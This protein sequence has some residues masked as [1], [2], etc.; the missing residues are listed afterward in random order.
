GA[1]HPAAAAAVRAVGR[2]LW[3]N[4]L[5]PWYNALLTA[6][7]LWLLYAAVRTLGHWALAEAN[8]AVIP[9]NL[10]LFLVGTYPRDQLWRIGLIT[11]GSLLLSGLSAGAFGGKSLRFAAA[12]GSTGALFLL[13]PFL[14]GPVRAGMAVGVA[15]L[16][17]GFLLAR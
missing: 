4:L 5:S 8:W 10:R 14:S 12:L 3:E 16:I 7:C 6:L 2:W 15:L 17:G 1:L 11:Y 9:A 13:F